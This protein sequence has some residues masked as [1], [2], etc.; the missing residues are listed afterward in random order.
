ML[1]RVYSSAH[2]Q[3][4]HCSEIPR[5]R[6]V[7]SFSWEPSTEGRVQA[8]LITFSVARSK[9]AVRAELNNSAGRVKSAP[10]PPKPE[11]AAP[12]VARRP[13]S[14]LSPT[15]FACLWDRT[16][17]RTSGKSP[18]GPRRHHKARHPA[19]SNQLPR[20]GSHARATSGRFRGCRVRRPRETGRHPGDPASHSSGDR[21]YLATL[22]R[23][24]SSNARVC[25]PP[26]NACRRCAGALMRGRAW[27]S[28]AAG[29][30]TRQR[31][32]SL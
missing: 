21:G 26:A 32:S 9:N 8:R 1:S 16:L 17:A 10:A 15:S 3:L 25:D 24:P 30:G 4:R 27:S 13:T 31:E 14:S 18:R 12:N 20:V 5:R 2:W 11:F 22:S 23:S 19:G 28:C 6:Q 7:V 29:A